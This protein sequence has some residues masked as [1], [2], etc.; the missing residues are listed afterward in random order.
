[1]DGKGYGRF[2]SELRIFRS[3]L[4]GRF[5]R[6]ACHLSTKAILGMCMQMNFRIGNY[7]TDSL[8][9]AF[10]NY[11]ATSWQ[12]YAPQRSFNNLNG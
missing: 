3:D 6:C 9:A 1:M 10:Q 12:L 5:R 11:Y 2:E 7:H 4:L 8:C